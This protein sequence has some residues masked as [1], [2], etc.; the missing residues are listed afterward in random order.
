MTTMANGSGQLVQ[1][2]WDDLTE[3]YTPRFPQQ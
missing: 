2:A 3:I 1:C